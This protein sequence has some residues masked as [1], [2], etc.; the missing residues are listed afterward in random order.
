MGVLSQQ[1]R[2]QT[3][4]ALAILSR[5]YKK[6]TN[7]F[8]FLTEERFKDT[9]RAP[10]RGLHDPNHQMNGHLPFALQDTVADACGP[11]QARG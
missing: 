10:V 11:I 1:S 3:K 9:V 7:T 6:I 8:G 4:P 2:H 5:I